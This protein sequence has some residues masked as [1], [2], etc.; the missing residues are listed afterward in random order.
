VGNVSVAVSLLSGTLAR[1]AT[2]TLQTL[3]NTALGVSYD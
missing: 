2:V 1:D 3:N